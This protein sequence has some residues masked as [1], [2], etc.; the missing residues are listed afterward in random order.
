M[1]A[2]TIDAVMSGLTA[3]IGAYGREV[4]VRTEETAGDATVRLG[5]RLLARL[6]RGEGKAH[7][8][9][10]EAVADVAQNPGD[11]DF[12][13]ALRAQVKKALSRDPELARDLA[14]LLREGGVTVTAAGE[15]AVAVGH[16]AGILSTG[17][18]ATNRIER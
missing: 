15:R 2:S 1:D 12:Q 14:G 8:A 5:L 18:G 13:A 10:E 9:V 3:A 4:L 16:N 11:E 17:D 7:A 6:R